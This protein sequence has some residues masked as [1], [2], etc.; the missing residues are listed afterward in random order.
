MTYYFIKLISTILSTLL[1]LFTILIIHFLL[2]LGVYARQLSEFLS[3]FRLLLVAVWMLLNRLRVSA[4]I[5]F[6][7]CH[8][9]RGNLDFVISMQGRGM[10]H[11]LT[12]SING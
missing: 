9:T 6:C 4:S 10:S 3:W 1:A 12:S 5:V 7:R 11:Q 8:Y 2:I